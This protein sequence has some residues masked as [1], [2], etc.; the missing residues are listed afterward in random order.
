MCSVQSA[1]AQHSQFANV[2]L[3][4]HEELIRR[5]ACTSSDRWRQELPTLFEESECVQHSQPA[6][7]NLQVQTVGV[8][9]S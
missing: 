4:R 9:K 5:S 6:C 2:H 3:Q 1:C 8:R 7:V